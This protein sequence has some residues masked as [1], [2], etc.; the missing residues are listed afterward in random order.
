M[1]VTKKKLKLLVVFGLASQLFNIA[2]AEQ[3]ANTTEFWERF[4]NKYDAGKNFLDGL[5]RGEGRVA[6]HQGAYVYKHRIEVPMGR[7]GMAPDIMLLYSSQ[8]K[9]S[10]I[11]SGWKLNI[12]FIQRSVNNGVPEYTV[13]DIKEYHDETGSVC[14]LIPTSKT[15]YYI[16]YRCK[17]VSD[18]KIFKYNLSSDSWTVMLKTGEVLYFGERGSEDSKDNSY[19]GRTF[20]WYINRAKDSVGNTVVYKYKKTAYTKPL[21]A[22]IEYTGHVY[23]EGVNWEPF[24]KV[25]F[26]WIRNQ[27]NRVHT[28]I[29]GKC[30]FIDHYQLDTIATLVKSSNVA[31]RLVR[32]YKL[33]YLDDG[34]SRFL[35]SMTTKGL[36]SK[37]KE[38][39]IPDM[40]FGYNTSDQAIKW[41]EQSEEVCFPEG[42][43]QF[44]YFAINRQFDCWGRTERSLIDMNGDGLLDY[45][46]GE[47]R[48][49]YLEIFFARQSDNNT[50]FIEPVTWNLPENGNRYGIRHNEHLPW[51]HTKSVTSRSLIDMNGDSLPDW[52]FLEFDE[53]Q[54]HIKGIRVSLN[55]LNGFTQPMN[56]NVPSNVFTMVSSNVDHHRY[57][58]VK[59]LELTGD[60]RPDVLDCT[61]ALKNVD[62]KYCLMYKNNGDG[63]D[64]TP[65]IWSVPGWIPS[66]EVLGM[67]NGRTLTTTLDVNGDGLR[68]L[69]TYRDYP[70]DR[71]IVYYNNGKGFSENENL[72]LGEKYID[73]S[74]WATPGSGNDRFAQEYNLD[75]DMDGLV[76]KVFSDENTSY[77]KRNGGRKLLSIASLSIPDRYNYRDKF[78]RT[79]AGRVVNRV[80]DFD[81][82]GAMDLVAAVDRYEGFPS[83]KK[84]QCIKVNFGKFEPKNVMTRIENGFGGQIQIDYMPA[85]KTGNPSL[86]NFIQV[87][88]S[89]EEKDLINGKSNIVQYTYQDG[90]LHV[91]SGKMA[92]IAKTEFR[93][94]GRVEKLDPT[95]AKVE[96]S[97][98]HQDDYL[99]GMTRFSYTNALETGRKLL[100]KRYL[101][102]CR[103][104]GIPL[105]VDL[106][107]L[108][109]CYVDQVENVVY[110]ENTRA[111]TRFKTKYEYS[112]FGDIEKILDFGA[113][114]GTNN[115]HDDREI[116]Y[117]YNCVYDIA[118][119]KY[120]IAQS[121]ME[122]YSAVGNGEM[123]QD[124]RVLT[125]YDNRN[126]VGT[127]LQ[128]LVTRRRKY[129]SKDVYIDKEYK[130]D[131]NCPEF[132][133]GSCGILE[134]ET[135]FERNRID[136][137]F[138]QLT[139]SYPVRK[140][141]GELTYEYEY[142]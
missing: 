10:E 135:D 125:F 81:S 89:V 103:T 35:K 48:Q 13:D 57:S 132:A 87:V 74:G 142:D 98:Y 41:A 94:F 55:N 50:R 127:A 67:E 93:G 80:V 82:D 44:P 126:E 70:L 62:T 84:Q 17:N 83:D 128:G 102:K 5:G 140:T 6:P 76:D 34:P 9:R 136:Y 7:R 124:G 108:K 28:C 25:K 95:R 104:E 129:K 26:D 85:N 141:F 2:N 18:Y 75:L 39:L 122:T 133:G 68:D 105:G 90:K 109:F 130:Y 119:E 139:K 123:A 134:W 51:N 22:S 72:V 30:R 21:A 92:Q 99:T 138:D 69:V 15:L 3:G 53:G 79:R 14:Y 27:N 36:N 49:N 78:G 64:Q 120:L 40:T 33:N 11:G 117:G 58:Y 61:E 107:K 114:T 113:V 112:R 111:S 121:K 24:A 46:V 38:S 97:Y 91:N 12:P 45:V 88:K 23:R 43:E 19:E 60:G 65:M 63:F 115:S 110:D 8:G 4:S 100:S 118:S 66:P 42:H 20:A 96:G 56:W 116:H 137:E 131:N 47:T 29:T 106:P 32:E 16:L 52:V 1:T 59:L 73:F 101:N 77:W 86:P 54:T 71:V 37:G 31:F